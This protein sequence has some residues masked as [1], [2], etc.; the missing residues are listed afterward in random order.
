MVEADLEGLASLQLK[1]SGSQ[2][3]SRVTMNTIQTKAAWFEHQSSKIEE[4]R[5][6][7]RS[8]NSSVDERADDDLPLQQSPLRQIDSKATGSI[9][10]IKTRWSIRKLKDTAGESILDA[11]LLACS[12]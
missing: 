11:L 3:G 10:S 4:E 7:T 5:T 9:I 2:Q 1:N 12:G 6:T 8:L